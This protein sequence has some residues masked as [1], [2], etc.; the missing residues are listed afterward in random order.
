MGMRNEFETS[1]ENLYEIDNF[2]AARDIDG[3]VIVN[4]LLKY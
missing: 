4:L 3:L 2:V 1:D